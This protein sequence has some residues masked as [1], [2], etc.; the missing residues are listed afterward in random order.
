GTTRS[1]VIKIINKLNL[2]FEERNIKLS[3]LI[4]SDE[5]FITNIV[6]E[7]TPVIEIKNSNFKN[8]K[9]GEM[10]KILQKEYFNL[11]DKEL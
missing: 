1:L 9:V 11:I 6:E 5:I 4:D 8:K 2:N 10:T 3:E 7:I